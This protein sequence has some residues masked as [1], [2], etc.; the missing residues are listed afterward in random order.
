MVFSASFS[1]FLVGTQLPCIQSDIYIYPISD[2]HRRF[3]MEDHKSLDIKN[4]IKVYVGIFAHCVH[5]FYTQCVL[6]KIRTIKNLEKI[7]S[8][9]FLQSYIYVPSLGGFWGL[10]ALPP[11][12][13]KSNNPMVRTSWTWTICQKAQ[14]IRPIRLNLMAHISLA[15]R[16]TI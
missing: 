15:L 11:L 10:T 4:V 5:I 9:V 13:W 16:R 2:I 8:L 14:P 6:R 3:G 12:I 7:S 1:F